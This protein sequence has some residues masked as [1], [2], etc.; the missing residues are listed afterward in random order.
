MKRKIIINKLN[1]NI[2]NYII[3]FYNIIINLYYFSLLI[4]IKICY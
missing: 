1:I 4:N 3:I 2:N